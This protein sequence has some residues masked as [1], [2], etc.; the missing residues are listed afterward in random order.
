MVG[1]PGPIDLEASRADYTEGF[2]TVWLPR[3]KPSQIRIEEET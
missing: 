3:A 2:L 1:L